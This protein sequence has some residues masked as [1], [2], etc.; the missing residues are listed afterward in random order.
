MRDLGRQAGPG[1]IGKD[2]AAT[3]QA[4]P[5]GKVNGVLVEYS[6]RNPSRTAC[7]GSSSLAGLEL[8]LA[9]LPIPARAQTKDLSYK[10]VNPSPGV[11][12]CL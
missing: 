6:R 10:T 3:V 7:F 2:G 4:G 9:P 11:G 12:S 8:T 5:S 1:V